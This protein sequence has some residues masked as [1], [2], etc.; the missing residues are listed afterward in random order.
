MKKLCALLALQV[1]RKKAPQRAARAGQS[2]SEVMPAVTE[3]NCALWRA[4]CVNI[5]V[6]MGEASGHR[7]IHAIYQLCLG[8]LLGATPPS[9]G[10]QTTDHCSLQ[11][12]QQTTDLKKEVQPPKIC[13]YEEDRERQND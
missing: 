1:R 13:Q 8:K 9:S 11:A 12:C 5:V 4:G 3:T 10:Q 6:G 2:R 7:D